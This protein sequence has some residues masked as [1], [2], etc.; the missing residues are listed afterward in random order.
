MCLEHD[1]S[2]D[3]KHKK[4]KAEMGLLCL[5]RVESTGINSWF[6]M[7]I[8]KSDIEMQKDIQ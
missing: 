8:K 6:S 7:D 2:E 1:E 3:Y 4:K 5:I